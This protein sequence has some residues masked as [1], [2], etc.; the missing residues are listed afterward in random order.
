MEG[1]EKRTKGMRLVIDEL[2]KRIKSGKDSILVMVV[3]KKGSAPRGAGAH[4]LVGKEGRILGTIG[5]GAIEYEAEKLAGRLLWEKNSRLEVFSLTPDEPQRGQL[6]ETGMVCGGEVKLCFQYVDDKKEEDRALVFEAA[7]AFQSRIRLWL[8]LED[9]PKGIR[10]RLAKAPPI[11]QC[12][13]VQPLFRTGTV[14]LFGGGHVAGKLV[15][16]LAQL[17]FSCVV[18]EDRREYARK[19][20]FPEAE[21]VMEIDYKRTDESITVREEDYIIIMTRGHQYD[22]I[23]QEQM[24]RTQAGY[25]GVMGSRKKKAYAEQQL[26]SAGFSPEELK[27]I[28]TP[29]GLSIGADTPEEIA[30]SIAAEL[31]ALRT[32]QKKKQEEGGLRL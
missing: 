23:I 7:A 24:L 22:M 28:K 26:Q 25:I 19:E 15:P 10:T 20:L 4:M 2:E 31:I 32:A 11:H 1:K 13:Y 8:F 5:G 16:L 9:T 14:Y 21:Q 12:I 3:S 18:L 29:I 27:R 17:D 30:V 6:K